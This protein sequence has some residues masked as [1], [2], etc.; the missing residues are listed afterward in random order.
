MRR[1]L[2]LARRNHSVHPSQRITMQNNHAI[3]LIDRG[4]DARAES[5]LLESL[6]DALATV[7]EDHPM[8]PLIRINLALIQRENGRLAQAGENARAALEGCRKLH[9]DRHPHTLVAMQSV[10]LNLAAMG[11]LEEAEA[12]FRAKLDLARQAFGPESE[13]ALYAA[14]AI[15][16]VL[17]NRGHLAEAEALVRD[18]Q[19][20]AHRI[21]PR[22]GTLFDGAL[23]VIY[24]EMGRYPEAERLLK[25][26]EAEGSRV[27]LHDK[28]FLL[29]LKLALAR[30]AAARGRPREAID[31][32]H[33]VL[34]LCQTTYGPEDPLTYHIL[35]DLAGAYRNGGLVQEAEALYPRVL[36]LGRS[37]LGPDHH[38]V[39]AVRQNFAALLHVRGRF[40]LA[41]AQYRE[42]LDA[43]T[44][45]RGAENGTTLQVLSNLGELYRDW[46]QPG[47]A[48]PLLTQALEG[49]GRVRGADHPLTL[50]TLWKLAELDRDRGRLAQADAMFRRC[51]EGYAKAQ[52]DEGL[53]LA[54]LRA[55]LA[56]THLKKGEPGRA[57]PLLREA[58]KVYDRQMP[59]DWRRF[60]IRGQLG[61]AL[62]AQEKYDEAE[63]LVLGGHEGLMARRQGVSVDA[64]PRLPEAGRRVVKL[65]ESWGKPEQAFRWMCRLGGLP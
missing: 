3:N 29:R 26:V 8:V 36:S 47:K 43:Y 39:L 54:M 27:Q 56:M 51:I 55:D 22:V 20:P 45:T 18:S 7:G 5:I 15:A 34:N 42:A 11:K 57:E 1:G 14:F 53:E 50:W 25:G 37:L 24:E 44:R 6:R 23:G 28:R 64:R 9:G 48:E 19:G 2:E 52:G 10:G 31:R 21:G 59:D 13:T 30:V 40:E 63:P 58:L 49:Q 41:E 4:A 16:G 65:Y 33:E 32:Y 60:E 17:R 61:E 62:A 12:I 46:G 35:S 38:D